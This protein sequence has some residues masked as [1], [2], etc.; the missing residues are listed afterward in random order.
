VRLHQSIGEH[1]EAAHRPRAKEIAAEL[2]VH[3]EQG[4]DYRRAIQYF[5]QAAENAARRYANREAVGNLIR[6]LAWVERLPQPEQGVVQMAL[7]EQ[8]GLVRRS[9]GD[10]KKAAEDF[11]ALAWCARQQGHLRDEVKALFHLCSALSWVDLGRCLATVEQAAERSHGLQ[12]EFFQVHAGGSAAYWHLL[13]HG[14]RDEDAQ[15]SAQAIEAARRSGDRALQSL[16]LPRYAYFQSLRSEYQAACRTILEGR[17][18]AFEVNSPFDSM[19]GQFFE[20]WALLHMGQWGK[21]LKT[22]T[23]AIEM[24]E[25]NGHQL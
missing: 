9:M 18:L 19:L 21:L 12:D 8:L 24:A 25:K 16:H 5:R 10:M 13:L 7:L 20:A 22:L 6:A 17:Q 14:W 2:A 15:A 23:E 3:F 11:E 1:L 4:R